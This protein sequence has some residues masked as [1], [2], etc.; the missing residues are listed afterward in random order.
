MRWNSKQ[1]EF[2][3]VRTRIKFLWWPTEINGETRWLELGMWTEVFTKG[4]NLT[5]INFWKKTTWV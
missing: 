5:C 4:S 3:T 2:G 1:P